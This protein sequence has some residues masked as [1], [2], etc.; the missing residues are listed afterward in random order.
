M[1]TPLIWIATLALAGAALPAAADV[2]CGDADG[3]GQLQAA[4]G[5]L[6]S[7]CVM[8]PEGCELD[9]ARADTNNDGV[10]DQADVDRVA[11]AVSDATRTQAAALT[12]PAR[13]E[14]P[15]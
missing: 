9:V 6:I 4:D 1:R 3:N 10:L 15:S 14:T 12:C 7:K 8:A 13:P 2:L 11:A 5:F